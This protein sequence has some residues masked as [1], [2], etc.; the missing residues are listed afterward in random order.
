[1]STRGKKTFESQLA[2]LSHEVNKEIVVT[3]SSLMHITRH[4]QGHRMTLFLK[5][6]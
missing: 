2:I 6:C 5:I 3:Y 4:G 1:M